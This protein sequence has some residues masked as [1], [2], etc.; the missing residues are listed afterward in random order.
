MKSSRELNLPK[1]LAPVRSFEGARMVVDAGADEIYLGVTVPGRL[2]N[3]WLNRSPLCEVPSYEELRK[4]VRYAHSRGV[5]VVLTAVFPFM[6]KSMESELKQHLK[7]CLNEGVDALII[8]D[9]GIL[10]MVKAMDIRVP[11]YASTFMAS[12]NYEAVEFLRKLG[13]SRVILERHLAIDEIRKIVEHS[14]V[15]IEVFI[16]GGGCSNINANCYLLHWILPRLLFTPL[17]DLTPCRHPFKV[18][19]RSGKFLG[20]YSILDGFTWC[21]LCRVPQLVKAGVSGFKIVGRCLS[22]ERQAV[23]TRVYREMLDF[24]ARGKFSGKAFKD[25]LRSLISGLDRYYIYITGRGFREFYCNQR[26]CYYSP[27]L[28]AQYKYS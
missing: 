3:L 22:G 14:R 15:E 26:R 20:V 27:L 10:S 18:Y 16:H 21:S 1:L 19:D 12:M 28:T 8:G 23:M 7:R 13:F 17:R 25:K 5:K 2:R 11:I 9:L 6:V 4:I 24:I